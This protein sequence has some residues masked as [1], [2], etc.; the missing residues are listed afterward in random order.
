MVVVVGGLGHFEE[1]P[2]KWA[3]D[4]NCAQ[5]ALSQ[6]GFQAVYPEFCPTLQ[7]T[8]MD[9]NKSKLRKNTTA[10]ATL[11][12]SSIRLLFT[13]HTSKCRAGSEYSSKSQRGEHIS[14][15]L[16]EL[17]WLPD[18]LIHLFLLITL[19]LGIHVRTFNTSLCAR[20]SPI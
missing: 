2:H 10:V 5:K 7:I 9:K 18:Q 15:N 17:H 1:S 20:T 13:M 4:A 6:P 8:N 16:A 3:E 14:P 12:S 19:E 11:I